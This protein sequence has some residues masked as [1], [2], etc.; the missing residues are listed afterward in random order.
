VIFCPIIYDEHRDRRSI[1]RFVERHGSSVDLALVL[2]MVRAS[3][4]L[5]HTDPKAEFGAI[6]VALVARHA[7]TQESIDASS[8]LAQVENAVSADGTELIDLLQQVISS[9]ERQESTIAFATS[10]GLTKGVT[11]YTDHTVPIA[12]HAWL[13]SP[14]DFR[15]AITT[16]IGCGGDADTT[17]AIVGSIVGA[18]VGR[19]GI[20]TEWIEGICEWPRSVSWMEQLGVA[21][22]D[23]MTAD[24]PLPA[25][26][27]NPL[28]VIV[29]NLFFL[30]V[31]LVHGFRRL[32][33]PY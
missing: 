33:P 13:S 31:V 23:Y 15:Q 10:L 27:V 1:T 7:R 17:A 18:G 26:T 24:Q 6:A 21:L 11:G 25:P 9:V 12:I 8:W 4:R 3:S 22:A 32:A 14:R 28:A 29:R 16:V 5:T 20:P 30:F 19:D 2:D